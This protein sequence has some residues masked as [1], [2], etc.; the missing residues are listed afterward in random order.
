MKEL[1]WVGWIARELGVL[2][3]DHNLLLRSMAETCMSVETWRYDVQVGEGERIERERYSTVEE[4][5][6]EGKRCLVKKFA[7]MSEVEKSQNLRR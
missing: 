4:R 1:D 7:W 5:M 3:Q 2:A 6:L